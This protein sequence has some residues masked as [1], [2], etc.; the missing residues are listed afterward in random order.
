LA[1][2]FGCWWLGT[3]LGE[4]FLALYGKEAASE[5]FKTV[6]YGALVFA[7]WKILGENAPGIWKFIKLD[8]RSGI[9][10]P[11]VQVAFTVAGFGLVGGSSGDSGR[12]RTSLVLA[13]SVVIGESQHID[14]AR[15][16]LPYFSNANEKPENQSEETCQ[17]HFEKLAEVTDKEAVRR[18]ACGLRA[19]SRPGEQVVVDVQGFASSRKFDCGV[20]SSSDR[21]LALAERRRA[22]VIALLEAPLDEVDCPHARLGTLKY[23]PSV[24][25]R[26]SSHEEM[27]Q[28]RDL[29]DLVDP[30]NRNLTNTAR[31]ILSRRV[32]LVVKDRGDCEEPDEEAVSLAS[33]TQ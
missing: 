31:E 7:L 16:L 14:R 4:R 17:K 3:W 8:D 20:V 30:K 29:N 28:S 13:S 9:S 1:L 25:N 18:L 32:D 12:E 6:S 27:E 15:I 19:C 33:N 24:G 23:E 26:W 21:N 10:R 11:L 22:N 5:V 2:L